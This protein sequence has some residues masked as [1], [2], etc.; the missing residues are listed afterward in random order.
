MTVE[1]IRDAFNK[2]YEKRHQVDI[3]WLKAHN[4]QTILGGLELTIEDWQ[5]FNDVNH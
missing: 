1:T 5:T 3:E 4:L 2:G